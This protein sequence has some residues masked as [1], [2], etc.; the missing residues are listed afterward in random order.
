MCDIFI[1][2][3]L[4]IGE[5][6]PGFYGKTGGYYG[7]VEQQGRLT[8]HLHLLLWL[9]SVLSPQDIRDKIMDPT[10]DFQ[11]KIVEYLESVHIGEFMTN[12]NTA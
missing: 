2:H 10:S 12:S 4:G 6:H 9:K 8:L 11:K 5:N 3:V 7:T 1:K